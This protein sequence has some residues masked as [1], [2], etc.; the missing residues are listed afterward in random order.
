MTNQFPDIETAL[1]S[2]MKQLLRSSARNPLGVHDLAV[3]LG[4][5]A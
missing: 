1:W 3:R 2:W 4:A 5:L